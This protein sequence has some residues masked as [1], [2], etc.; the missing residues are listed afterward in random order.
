MITEEK[1]NKINSNITF[2]RQMQH[3]GYL[4]LHVSFTNPSLGKVEKYKILTKAAKLSFPTG[5]DIHALRIRKKD[6][7]IIFKKATA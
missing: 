5:I 4:R 3:E 6:G 7:T 1:I 2:T